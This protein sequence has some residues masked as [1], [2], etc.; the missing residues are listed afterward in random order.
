M[1]DQIKRRLFTLKMVAI[2]ALVPAATPA[3]VGISHASFRGYRPPESG[4]LN[5]RLIALTP[6]GVTRWRFGLVSWESERQFVDV[7]PAITSF[8]RSSMNRCMTS[9]QWMHP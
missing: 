4:G 8:P 1:L 5:P 9:N 6:A 3:G 7:N 2:C